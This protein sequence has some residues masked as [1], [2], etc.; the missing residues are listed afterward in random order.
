LC[1]G[2]TV[3]CDTGKYQDASKAGT[4]V[5]TD[6]KVSCC[7]AKATCSAFNAAADSLT[8]G[9]QQPQPNRIFIIAVAFAMALLK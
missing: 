2:N 9:G 3:T 4:A 8:S 1:G 6:A 7:T 5:G